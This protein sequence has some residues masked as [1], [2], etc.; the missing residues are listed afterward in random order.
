MTRVT[1]WTFNYELSRISVIRRYNT[2]QYMNKTLRILFV[3]KMKRKDNKIQTS[4]LH[5]TFSFVDIYISSDSVTV[6]HLDV[7][8]V[9]LGTKL[10]GGCTQTWRALVFMSKWLHSRAERYGGKSIYLA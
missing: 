1:Y 7:C 3:I 5:L 9:V 6:L 10:V 4:P 8:V 2:L